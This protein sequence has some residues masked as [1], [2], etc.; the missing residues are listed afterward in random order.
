MTNSI[1]SSDDS[2]E[3]SVQGIISGL[4]PKFDGSFRFVP[5]CDPVITIHPVTQAGIAG[6]SVTLNCTGNKNQRMSSSLN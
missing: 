5:S 2:V 6:G 4:L 3:L 1:G